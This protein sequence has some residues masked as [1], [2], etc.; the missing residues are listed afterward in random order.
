[1]R[2]FVKAGHLPKV[3]EYVHPDAFERI[4]ELVG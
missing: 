1:V 4:R 3:E 2:R